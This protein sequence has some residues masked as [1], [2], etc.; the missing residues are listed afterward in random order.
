[1]KA[2]ATIL[3]V[4][5]GTSLK[6]PARTYINFLYINKAW[7]FWGKHL[8]VD[9]EL[10]RR[11]LQALVHVSNTILGRFVRRNLYRGLCALHHNNHD[12][13]CKRSS[14]GQSEARLIPRSSIWFRLKPENSNSHGFELHRPSTMGIKL[15]LSNKSNHH[16]RVWNAD[17][18]T[19]RDFLKIADDF[20]ISPARRPK[21]SCTEPKVFHFNVLPNV[22]VG[23]DLLWCRLACSK[24]AQQGLPVHANWCLVWH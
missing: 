7:T 24:S 20:C 15:L 18:S 5:K 23:A 8:F 10:W 22:R 11:D 17:S 21:H 12:L 2:S 14:V 9:A 4:R 3:C 13:T 16:H 6:N 19:L 1:M